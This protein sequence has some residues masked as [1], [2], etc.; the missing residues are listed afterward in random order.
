M[1]RRSN[2]QHGKVIAKQASDPDLLSLSDGTVLC[3]YESIEDGKSIVRLARMS[4]V[5]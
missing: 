4:G 1:F 3:C 2:E 5:R